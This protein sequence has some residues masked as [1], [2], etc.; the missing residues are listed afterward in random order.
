MFGL[1]G[2]KKKKIRQFI[3]EGATIIDVRTEVEYEGGRLRNSKNIPLDRLPGFIGQLDKTKP[4][5]PS[6][7]SGMRSASAA[8]LLK[9]Q[10]FDVVNGGGW[11]KLDRLGL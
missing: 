4:V 2:G 9:A 11:E 8:R 3:Q 6:C 1:F 7:A 10:G 5:I